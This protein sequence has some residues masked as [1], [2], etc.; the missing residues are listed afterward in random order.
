MAKE[1][2]ARKQ[3]GWKVI[4]ITP[5]VCKTPMGKSKPPVPYSAIAHLDT[6]VEVADSVRM[7]GYPVITYNMSAVPTT[8]GDGAGISK[9]IKSGTVGGKCYPAEH[10]SSVRA[11]KHLL[12]RHNDKFEMNAP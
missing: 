12:V 6:S 4:G 1:I 11:E 9:G 5:D 7:N 2:G 8:V 3:S 10:S